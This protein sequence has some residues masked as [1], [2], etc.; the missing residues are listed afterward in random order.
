MQFRSPP[1]PRR[2]V[3]PGLPELRSN[4]VRGPAQRAACGP[5]CAPRAYPA[6]GPDDWTPA[7]RVAVLWK[8]PPSS[9]VS[10]PGSA[11]CRWR[12]RRGQSPLRDAGVPT[13]RWWTPRVRRHSPQPERPWGSIRGAKPGLGPAGLTVR[14]PAL[15]RD[16]APAAIVRIFAR[17]GPVAPRPQRSSPQSRRR[18][19]S[20]V[21][22]VQTPPA[23][24]HARGP[25]APAGASGAPDP[26]G[27]APGMPHHTGRP[28]AS[29]RRERTDRRRRMTI[30][31]PRS[32][33]EFGRSHPVPSPAPAA[34]RGAECTPP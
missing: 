9:M 33:S 3:R 2:D 20:G 21:G 29:P 11:R 15:R 18:F 12:C 22:R 34:R 16:L 32:P 28:A 24:A 10:R 7:G 5:G 30:A 14:G 23:A 1:Q 8:P 6:S 25:H 17:A 19:A 26:R 4:A 13:C 31:A 27:D